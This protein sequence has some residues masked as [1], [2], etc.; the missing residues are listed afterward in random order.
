MSRG[1]ENIFGRGSIVVPV[2]GE[3]A[4]T[5]KQLAKGAR[6]IDPSSRPVNLAKPHITIASFRDIPSHRTDRI[7]DRAMDCAESLV[8]CQLVIGGFK[9]FETGLIG[10]D[11][12]PKSDLKDARQRLNQGFPCRLIEAFGFSPHISVLYSAR[13]LAR[14]TEDQVRNLFDQVC[15]SMEIEKLVV[16]L[17]DGGRN[18]GS[19]EILIPLTS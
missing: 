15:W 2:V 4:S 10:L 5:C 11:V 12:S 19:R 13:N 1:C 6:E 16:W 18:L 7:K 3:F 17:R 8:G 9:R 14:S